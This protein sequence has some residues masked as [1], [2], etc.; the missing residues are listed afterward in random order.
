MKKIL[1]TG[2]SGRIGSALASFLKNSYQV[3]GIDLNRG[4]FT[5]HCLDIAD[6]KGIFHLTKGV[7]AIVHLAALLPQHINVYSDEDFW[8]TNVDGTENL[9]DACLKYNIKRFVFTST[10]S[11]YGNAMVL[12]HQAVWVTEDLLPQPRDIYDETKLAAEALCK[13]AS[14]ASLSCISLR[15]SRCFPEEDRLMAIYRLYRGVDIRDV[16]LGHVLAL[17]S[18]IKGYEF[19]NITSQ[20]PFQQNDLQELHGKADDVIS[21][22]HPWA[23]KAFEVKGWILPFIIDRVYVAEKAKKI[24]GYTAL[25][26]FREIMDFSEA[27]K[28]Q[29]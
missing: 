23:K 14:G 3:I 28:S 1:I 11:I 27:P 16:V 8:R 5:T 24:L 25:Y 22:Y 21:R 29:K 15:M 7:D 9:L 26:N 6:K 18:S 10:T 12:P 19:F 20:T 17:E 2:T 4:P 13:N